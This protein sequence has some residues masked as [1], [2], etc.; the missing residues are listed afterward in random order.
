M[1]C[2][3]TAESFATLCVTVTASFLILL[4]STVQS[5]YLLKRKKKKILPQKSS[6]PTGRRKVDKRKAV[7]IPDMVGNNQIVKPCVCVLVLQSH[8]Q[9]VFYSKCVTRT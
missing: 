5:E 9:V 1:V 2:S 6:T 8:L 7:R 4:Y 3:A